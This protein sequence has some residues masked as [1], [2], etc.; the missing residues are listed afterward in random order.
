MKHFHFPLTAD[1]VQAFAYPGGGDCFSAPF[2]WPAA[3]G[4]GCASGWAALRVRTFIDCARADQAAVE[5]IERLPWEFFERET[6]EK[7]WGKLDDR[8]GG[9]W[10]H[11]EKRIWQQMAGGRWVPRKLDRVNMGIQGVQVT[12]GLLQLVSKLP[13]AEV[14]TGLADPRW[15]FFRFNGGEGVV[16]AFENQEKRPCGFWLWQPQDMFGR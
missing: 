10:R 3:D 5:R 13:R 16:K 9:L 14:F 1:Q 12:V 15:L 7:D 4:W 6:K 2:I 8:R 11:G